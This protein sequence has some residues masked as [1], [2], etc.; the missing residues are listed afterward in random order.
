MVDVLTKIAKIMCKLNEG[1]E[2]GVSE[3]THLNMKLESYEIL[4]DLSIYL[5]EEID[6]LVLPESLNN[7]DVIEV[8]V[9]AENSIVAAT[10]GITDIK[11]IISEL[12]K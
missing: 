4:K 12:E 2:E 5:L 8:K 6:R 7:K 11:K 10:K 9:E 3:L 1:P